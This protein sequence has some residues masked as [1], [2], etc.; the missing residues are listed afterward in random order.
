[1]ILLS[2]SLVL[3]FASIWHIFHSPVLGTC[4]VCRLLFWRDY[5]VVVVIII[6]IIIIIIKNSELNFCH[7]CYKH[8]L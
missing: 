1:M 6:I 3:P 2:G 5:V 8:K 7:K 4:F